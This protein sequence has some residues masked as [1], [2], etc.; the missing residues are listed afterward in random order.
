MV[1]SGGVE[2]SCSC[3]KSPSLPCPLC[4]RQ[5][6]VWGKWVGGL[7]GGH[8]E[9][10]FLLP[11]RTL[12]GI[13]PELI[14]SKRNPYYPWCNGPRAGGWSMGNRKTGVAPPSPPPPPSPLPSLLVLTLT[15][16]LCNTE[17]IINTCNNIF[18]ASNSL[19]QITA[20]HSCGA[21]TGIHLQA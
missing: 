3:L 8:A 16:R 15:L 4:L 7:G 17:A 14:N 11:V 5:G 2:S 20:R 12:S 13:Q 19:L 6:C 18:T 21:H 1:G 10:S 9:S